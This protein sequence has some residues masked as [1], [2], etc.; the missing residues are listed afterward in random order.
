MNSSCRWAA[1]S[2]SLRSGGALALFLSCVLYA[3]VASATQ[4]SFSGTSQADGHPVSGTA[5]FTLGAGTATI[6]LTNTTTTTHDA[7]E[8]FTGI[9]FSLGG[10]S[11]G[12]SSKTGIERTV[13]DNGTFTDTGS[14]QN[15]TWSLTAKG[16][17]VFQLDFSP[18]AT[19]AILGPPSGGNY[20]GANSSIDGNNGHNPFV[21]EKAT[22]VI[23]NASITANTSINVSNFLFD[24]GPDPANGTITV[25]NPPPLTPEPSTLVL[26]VLGAAIAAFGRRR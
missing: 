19:D 6:V 9:K 26:M 18:D 8:L 21:G 13:A 5:D 20:S 24:T 11:L 17:G 14:A 4:I 3:P 7:G 12:L 25:G 23:T 15:L 16:S 1:S 2:R 22:F 10:L